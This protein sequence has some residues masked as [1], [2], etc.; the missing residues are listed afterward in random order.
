MSNKIPPSQAKS[1][2]DIARETF[3]QLA[4]QRI[5]P[6]P[7]AYRKLYN[8]IAGIPD[9]NPLTD[10]DTVQHADNGETKNPVS[11]AENLLNSFAASLQNSNS[12]L[13][14]FGHRFSRAVKTGNWE[15]Y[16]KGLELL[17][18]HITSSPAVSATTAATNAPPSVSP[19]SSNLMATGIS[20]VDAPAEDP[21]QK[22]LKDLLYR[23]LTLALSSLLKSNPPLASESEALGLAVRDADTEAA[24]NQV[25]QRLKQLCFQIELQS[26]DSAE[27]H[28]L[29]LRLFDLLLTNIH[30]L[31]DNDNWLRG[32]IE[33]VQNLISGPIDHRA[34]QEATRSLKDV[35]YKQG[36]LKNSISESKTSV[37]NMM[38]AFIDRLNTM[39]ASTGAYQQKMDAYAG[40]I[41]AARDANEV[42]SLIS[43]ILAETRVVQNET[44]RSRDIIIAAQKEVA[45]A[46][47]R[48]KE[49]ENKLAHMS[50]LV[51]EDQLTG[52]LN[53]R[54]MEDIFDREADRADRRNTPLCVA[55]LDLDNFKKL[56]DVHG[57]AV[58]DEA[59]VHLV[60]IVKQTLRSIDVIARYGG[61]EF[62]IIM[63]ET[64]L[65][66]A[67]QAMIRVQRELTRH[68]FTAN[69]QR[70]FITFSA[71]VAMRAP[72][73]PQEILLKRADK[74]MYEAKQTGKNRVVKA[75]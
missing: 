37:K 1:P 63:P 64:G 54:G 20:L 59:L 42:T 50:E 41:S 7:D 21:R 38:E 10:T 47:T 43:H 29:L 60:R 14:T 5:A 66:E 34:L 33:V 36:V 17:T 68:F 62:V 75:I 22:L 61:E 23:T 49:L 73:E 8:E 15:D 40:K 39:V 55:L 35:I 72:R 44:L 56:N 53:R 27:Q 25:G 3:R 11:E 2:T 58:G 28:E 6:T 18:Q 30:D 57:H 69:D 13:S 24:L 48:I 70:L 9:E 4:I 67:A 74:A 12:D 65:D 26:G 46:E 32:Q 19:A 51:R 45:E 52:S 31:L 71:G 16:A